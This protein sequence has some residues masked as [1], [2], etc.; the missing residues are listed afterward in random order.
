MPNSFPNAAHNIVDIVSPCISKYDHLNLSEE[1]VILYIPTNDDLINHTNTPK[2]LCL[3][4]HLWIRISAFS[5][6]K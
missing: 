2:M 1:V 4:D 3:I 5:L 6:R